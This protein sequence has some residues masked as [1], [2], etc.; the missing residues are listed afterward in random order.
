MLAVQGRKW[1]IVG[2][3]LVVLA[4]C[5][6][7]PRMTMPD[8]DLFDRREAAA[9]DT[10]TEIDDATPDATE[11][12]VAPP[13]IAG[14]LG[15]TVVSLGAASEPG[16]WLK[17]PLVDREQKGRVYHEGLWLAVTLIPI[18]GAATAGSRMSLAAMRAL[19]LP[20][21]GLTEVRVTAG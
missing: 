18:E 11:D 16:M 21:T 15:T 10:P 3:A 13:P 14:E 2:G 17:T 5:D 8:W 1:G 4:G 9:P 20:L 7:G 6:G 19:E 12:E